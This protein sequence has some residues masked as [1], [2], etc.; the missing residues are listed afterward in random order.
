M[1]A[2][3]HTE[4]LDGAAATASSAGE[5]SA[6]ASPTGDRGG[7]VSSLACASVKPNRLLQSSRD[8]GWRGL[9][10]DHHQGTG[11]SDVFETLPTNDVTLVVA[12]RGRSLIQVFKQSRWRSALYDV[13]N[14]G[15]TEPH[16]T[17]RMFWQALDADARFE[18]AHLYLSGSIVSDV[19]EEYRRAGSRHMDHPLSSL[20]FK[21][22]AV[23]AIAGSLL[24][25]MRQGAPP[26][27]AEQASRF[28]ISH[29]LTRHARWWDPDSDCR[30]APMISDRQVARVL[31]YMSARFAEDLTLPELAAEA[32]ISVN[33]FVR[34]F[35]ER[36]GVTP[37]AYLTRL[38]IEAAQR[39]LL[40]SDIAISEIASLCGYSNA[41]A[42]SSAF[43]RHVG[44]SPRSYRTNRTT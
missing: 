10:L 30:V 18:T 21:D 27:Y 24:L 23:G 26:L 8:L 3:S 4:R 1:T 42:F 34:R 41:G 9:L 20:V 7:G 38:R 29:L 14:A 35:R 28:V 16:G 12:T 11:K 22:E 17:T 40:T 32:C 13:G 2:P 31:E 37:F 43:H 6:L 44:S 25:A 36:I 19:A 15:L 33:H 5:G 39:M